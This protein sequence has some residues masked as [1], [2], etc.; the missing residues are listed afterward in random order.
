METTITLTLGQLLASA[1]TI[2][3]AFIAAWIAISGRVKALEVSTE[4]RFK[5]IETSLQHGDDKF[6]R[7]LDE[8]TEIKLSLKDK[9]DK[10]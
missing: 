9:Q 2:A 7:I 10:E 1:T 3:V 6:D 8:L 5:Q 4:I